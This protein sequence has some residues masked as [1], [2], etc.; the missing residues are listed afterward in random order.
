METAYT[1][2]ELEA[3]TQVWLLA[4]RK[5]REEY[6]NLTPAG[7]CAIFNSEQKACSMMLQWVA[8]VNALSPDLATPT[9]ISPCEFTHLA[10]HAVLMVTSSG[11]AGAHARTEAIRVLQGAGKERFWLNDPQNFFSF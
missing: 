3:I 4:E 9:S 8:A 5:Y 6:P 2:Q 7:L 10:R 11:L 1:R